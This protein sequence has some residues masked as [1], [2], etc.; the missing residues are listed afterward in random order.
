MADILQLL[1]FGIVFGSILALGAIGIS[2]IFG[3]L[4]FA[5]FAHGDL[6]TVGAYFALLFVA[7]LDWPVLLAL[8][9]AMALTAVAAVL[10]D[11]VLYRH[12]R[13][14]SPVVLLI[15]SFGMALVLRSLV[16]IVAGSENQVYVSGITLPLVIG[17][18][19]IKPDHLTIVAGAVVLVA[20]FHLFLKK[21]TMGKAMRAMSDNP[22]LARI[23]G[24][25]TDRVVLWTWIIGGC[26]AAAAGVFLALDTRLNPQLGWNVLLPMF[27]AAIVGGIGRPYGAIAGG[28]VIGIAT[29]LS[30]LVFLPAYKPAVAFIFMLIVLVWRPTGIFKG[31]L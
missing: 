24:I 30:T 9:A 1:M 13:R 12:F 16:Q 6:M 5:H 3:I 7:V 25:D 15:S 31:S 28:L 23:S 18:L 8:P 21:T 4:R 11:R 10:I 20:A 29:E 17:E 26:L 22:D 19:R 27:A 14:S 2:V